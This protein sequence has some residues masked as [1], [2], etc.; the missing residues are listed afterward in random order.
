M[1]GKIVI[2]LALFLSAFAVVPNK[3]IRGQVTFNNQPVAGARISLDG[4]KTIATTD[5]Q[6]KFTISIPDFTKPLQ[7]AAPGFKTQ[8]VTITSSSFLD[9]VMEKAEADFDKQ[10]LTVGI[11]EQAVKKVSP[12]FAGM[13]APLPS[14]NVMR[15]SS[16]LTDVTN[17]SYKLINENGFQVTG[18]QAVTTFAADVDRASY[19]NIR[20][21]LT[22][23]NLPPADAVRIEEMINYFD[24]DY[25]QPKGDSPI[26]L[27]TELT[28]SPWN[29]GLKLL[30]IG[31]QAK[32]VAVQDLPASNLV[33]L[34]DVSG[35]MT[36]ENKLPLVKQAL[37]LLVG[38]L[39]EQD[40]ISIVA[41]AGAAG[42][43]LPP[44]SGSEKSKIK[45]ALDKLEAG[46]STAGGEGIEL[47]YDLA[48]AHFISK[49][50]NRVILATDGDFNVGVS[51][52]AGLQRLIEQ[53]RKS[54]IFLSVMGFGM[55]NYKDNLAETLA[56]KGNG[57]YAYIDNLQEAK[58]EFVHEFGGTLFTVAKD[59][60][61][62]I[63]FNPLHVQGYRLIGYETRAL[64]NEEFHDDKKDA[65]EMGSGHIVTA[66][67]ELIPAGFNSEYLPKTDP[68]KY[69]KN[70]ISAT[71][72]TDEMLTIKVRYKEPDS[73]KSQLFD[74][75]VGNSSRPFAS[76]SEN[77]RFSAAVAEFGL[78]LRDSEFKGEATY[79]DVISKAQ[80]ALGKDNEGYRAEFV[81]LV[82]TARSLQDPK[83]TA[84]K[85]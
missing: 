78:L 57:N 60:K 34:V 28:D 23:G 54:G 12:Q 7:V 13:S 58:K 73:E 38:Q 35:S 16:P 81:Q 21:Y 22:N 24:Y 36:D 62:Q 82:K 75:P 27:T 72:K 65:G 30:H 31:M 1:K 10:R 4:S 51:S 8:L 77:L 42:V 18:Q 70:N 17:E 68:L 19:S 44:T 69:Q 14:S 39:R 66:I 2:L 15:R 41:Y 33:F 64:K 56:D 46:G 53:K 20:R 71:G 6:G 85:E 9:I 47:A 67:Y 32:K 63:E 74:L 52:E 80:N 83:E 84:I 61:I 5:Q 48:A 26:A 11:Y 43:I 45:D 79:G 25:P 40:K 50:N 29:K 37:K 76:C 55:G 3:V 49:G 59:V